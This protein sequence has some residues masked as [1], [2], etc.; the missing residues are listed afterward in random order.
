VFK[1][2][3]DEK[4]IKENPFS[5]IKRMKMN[6]IGFDYF[7]EKQQNYLEPKIKLRD[8]QLYLFVQFIKY[9]C[10]R[11]KELIK[12]RIKDLNFMDAEVVV[13]GEIS[14]NKRTESVGMMKDFIKLGVEVY[15]LDTYPSEYFVFGK[16]GKPS[17][18][19]FSKPEHFTK[20]HNDLLREVGMETGRGKYSLYSW[21]ATGASNIHR[22]GIPI[23][24]IQKHLRHQNPST[25][26]IYLAKFPNKEHNPIKDL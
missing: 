25:T 7:T 2:C 10:I 13:R 5:G 23:K 12:L 22:K 9:L 18:D 21:K 1:F 6:K 4:L 11:P 8:E 16:N 19:G 3:I 17:L 15:Q 26:D 14:K 24:H 20:I